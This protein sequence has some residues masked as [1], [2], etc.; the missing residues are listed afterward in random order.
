MVT[1]MLMSKHS[2]LFVRNATCAQ[3]FDFVLKETDYKNTIKL[4]DLKQ[5]NIQLC[6]ISR[7][8][9]AA[10]V[11]FMIYSQLLVVRPSAL[12]LKDEVIDVSNYSEFV[13]MIAS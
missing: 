6:F 5:V 2:N 13:Q 11:H 4:S 3:V 1:D 12:V 8:L 9:H 7:D 10:I